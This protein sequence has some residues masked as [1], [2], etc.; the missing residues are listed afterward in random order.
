M[1]LDILKSD[2][3][4]CVRVWVDNHL[5]GGYFHINLLR[6]SNSFGCFIYSCLE[7]CVYKEKYG[8]SRLE[9]ICS[10]DIFKGLGVIQNVRPLLHLLLDF[11]DIKAKKGHHS[12]Y[13]GFPAQCMSDP[14]T[15]IIS[16]AL[17]SY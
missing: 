5:E 15:V 6:P 12:I 17:A 1:Q 8:T 2:V 14:H 10:S 16:L 13:L 7:P 4:Q 11:M 3:W 9:F